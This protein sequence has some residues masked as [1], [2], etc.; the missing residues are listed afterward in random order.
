V[1][2]A[3]FSDVHTEIRAGGSR[4]SWNQSYPLDLGPDLTGMAGNVDLA[5]LAGDIGTIRPRRDVGVLAYAEQ[6]GAFLRCPVVLVPGN[7]EYYRGEFDADRAAVLSTKRPGVSVLDRGEA[8]F[9]HPA[10]C[11]RVLGATL[12]TD[13]KCLGNQES[14]MFEAWRTMNDHRLIQRAGGRV[15][16]PTDALEEHECSRAWMS[17]KFSELHDGPTLIV[18]HHVPHSAA[19]HPRLGMT[20]LSPAFISNCDELIRAAAAI[21]AVGWVFGHHHWTHTVEVGGIRLLS[22]QPGYPG[23]QT[24]WAGSGVLEI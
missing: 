15:F 8:F 17:A 23:E 4:H 13:Y 10:G 12:W 24:N 3:Y 21:N 1:R 20:S 11:L 14:G 19:R 2:I 22:A 16:L 18:T 5:V 7:H 9:A 6:V